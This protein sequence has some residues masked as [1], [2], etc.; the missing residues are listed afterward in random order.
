[1]AFVSCSL[2]NCLQVGRLWQEQ[3]RSD[4]DLL[5]PQ[6]HDHD[7]CCTIT[8]DI[9]SSY[10]I[11]VV[12]AKLFHHKV[13]LFPCNEYFVK[14]CLETT[15][16]TLFLTELTVYSLICLSTCIHGLLSYP[17]GY[18]D[19]LLLFRCKKIFFSD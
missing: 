17:V 15:V 18:I 9:S 4:A 5:L 10:L 6:S 12:S 8:A 16:N 11:K 14:A 19:I 7:S 3:H 1:M 2:N 13:T